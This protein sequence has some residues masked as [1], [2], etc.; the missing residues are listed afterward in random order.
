MNKTILIILLALG[1]CC[2]VQAGPCPTTFMDTYV[3][4]GFS[5][6]IGSLEFSDF[7]YHPTGV[8]APTASQVQVVPISGAES[9]FEF[10][11]GWSAG[12]GNL[13]D[14]AIKYTVTCLACSIVDLVLNM[15]GN[16]ATGDSF[17]NIAETAGGV[18][19]PL[20]VG[21]S[22]N[23]IK[24]TD[25][26]TFSPVG[27]L[28]LTKDIL[29]NGGST[30]FGAAVSEVDNFFSTTEMSKV[31]EPRLMLLCSGFLCLLPVVRRKLRR[32]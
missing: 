27:S 14:S 1:L 13:Q 31:P 16:S 3:M 19:P 32:A 30:G 17:L 8:L 28:N 20:V 10:F 22:S 5:C 21:Q 4:S 23:T 11:A 26:E 6:D 12:P 15:E 29:L 25:S 9:G 18:V 2:V 24:S 7:S